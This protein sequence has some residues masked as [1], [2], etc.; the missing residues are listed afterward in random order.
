MIRRVDAIVHFGK[1][2][3]NHKVV[4]MC[5][6]TADDPSIPAGHAWTHDH[7]QVTCEECRS[8]LIKR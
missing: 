3:I 1:P 5:R 8:K 4:A 7:N 2:L 6:L